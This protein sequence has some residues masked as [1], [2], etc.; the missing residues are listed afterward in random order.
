LLLIVYFM[1]KINVIKFFLRL[2]KKVHK[3]ANDFYAFIKRSIKGQKNFD[4]INY[5]HKVSN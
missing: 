1:M 2:Y 3:G 5:H 4:Y